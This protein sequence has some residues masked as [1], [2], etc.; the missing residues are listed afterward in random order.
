MVFDHCARS[1]KPYRWPQCIEYYQTL[2]IC[3]EN[4]FFKTFSWIFYFVRV[5]INTLFQNLYQ[6]WQ[7]ALEK[8]RKRVERRARRLVETKGFSLW[9]PGINS[10]PTNT[11]VAS[12]YHFYKKGPRTT[13]MLFHYGLFQIIIRY[14]LL[15]LFVES[16]E[17]WGMFYKLLES[18]SKSNK[19]ILRLWR[20]KIFLPFLRENAK[21]IKLSSNFLLSFL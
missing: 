4:Y 1:A 12:F 9:I 17:F 3:S 7:K 10:L 15:L 19:A 13:R 5:W 21:Y 8:G 11:S 18:C 14:V 20:V 2:T 16:D 6:A